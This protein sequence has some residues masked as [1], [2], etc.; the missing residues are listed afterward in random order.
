MGKCIAKSRRHPPEVP[1][2]GQLLRRLDSADSLAHLVR[3]GGIVFYP[4]QQTALKAA[5]LIAK[6]PGRLLGRHLR[7]HIGAARH[8]VRE[9][10]V[11]QVGRV[12]L[13]AACRQQLAVSTEQPQ[14][15]IGDTVDQ[16]IEIIRKCRV[17]ALGPPEILHTAGQGFTLKVGKE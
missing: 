3:A 15:L 5:A 14:R 2:C 8:P 6:V 13:A 9:V 16:L 10:G 11:I 17:P 1:L 7:E 4:F 12:G